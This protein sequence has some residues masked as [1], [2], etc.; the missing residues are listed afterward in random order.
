MLT[1][2]VSLTLLAATVA[3][4]DSRPTPTGPTPAVV[5]SQLTLTLTRTL[6]GEYRTD[7]IYQGVLNDFGQIQLF[8]NVLGAEARHS[9]IVGQRFT[10]RGLAVPPSTS[11]V[12][13]VPHFATVTAACAAGAAAERDIVAKYDELLRADLPPDVRQAFTNIREASLLNH[14][15]AF[16]RCS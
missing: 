16:E 15:P 13:T 2:L 8:V 10:V 14:L 7:A 12:A 11:S 1:Q 4:C 5:E 9:A 3:A 6:Q